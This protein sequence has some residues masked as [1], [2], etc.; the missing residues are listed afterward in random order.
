[1]PDNRLQLD[2]WRI[3]RIL[4]D[5]VEGFETMVSIGPSVSIFGS[6]RMSPDSP[7]YSMS[8]D[9]SQRISQKGFAII[10]GGGPG[11][12]EAANEGAQKGK[13]PSCGLAIAIPHEESHNPYIDK[14]YLLYTRYFFVRKVL[15]IRYAVACV[16]M[17]GGFGTMDELFETL[18]LIQTKK[19]KKIPIFL[20]GTS[21]W[22][23]MIEWLKEKTI[24]EGFLDESELDL[25]CVTDDIDYVAE[26]IA[27][28]ASP[29]VIVPTFDLGEEV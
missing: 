12:M 4:A 11:A 3:F 21:Y 13:S 17:P 27:E 22:A 20:L 25:F 10:T 19:I 1:M 7:Y 15:F 9:L 26:Q 2:S 8:R 16:F 28:H 18:T 24:A 6:S 14:Q 29:E 23:G 5:F